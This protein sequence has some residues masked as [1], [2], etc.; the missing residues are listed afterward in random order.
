MFGGGEEDNHEL[1]L[2]SGAGDTED[3]ADKLNEAKLIEGDTEYEH[4][5]ST[6]RRGEKKKKKRRIPIQP[7]SK[8]NDPT[9]IVEEL[10]QCAYSN[11]REE[12]RSEKDNYEEET[13]HYYTKKLHYHDQLNQ[14]RL[15][16]DGT[17]I[18]TTIPVSAYGN[19]RDPNN[20]EI[21]YV[22][23]NK[24]EGE[25]EKKAQI[26]LSIDCK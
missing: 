10:L 4:I 2:I 19:G 23:D 16:P 1:K 13:V 14:Q 8:V 26:L 9:K 6:P 18:T 20:K 25:D 21:I 22:W 7:P 5:P 24:N 12:K 15:K 11:N 3:A 17:I